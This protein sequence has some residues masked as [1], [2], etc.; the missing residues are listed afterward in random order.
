MVFGSCVSSGKVEGRGVERSLGSWERKAVGGEAAT[1]GGEAATTGGEAATIGG[2]AAAI[3]G[4]PAM[5]G[6]D[7][8]MG[9]GDAAMGGGDAAMGG[10]DAAMGGADAA[11]G[12]ADAAIGGS[13]AAMGGG[14][15]AMAGGDLCFSLFLPN[16][17]LS[18]RSYF[19]GFF[20]CLDFPSSSHRFLLISISPLP[21]IPSPSSHPQGSRPSS[22][23]AP[24]QPVFSSPCPASTSSLQPSP[25]G[26]TLVLLPAIHKAA[27]PALKKLWFDLPMLRNGI[28]C[29]TG[30]AVATGAANLPVRCV[31]H[32]VGPTYHSDLVSAPLLRSAYR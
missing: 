8:A 14:V 32:A 28:R 27:G 11:M 24:F 9:G 20:L 19:L 1:T 13:D 22:Q 18:L 23:E 7:P 29:E 12:G 31:I 16:L 15:A 17:S 25:A 3:G 6:G 30:D 21:V 5:G 10:A 26:P 4:D 2:E